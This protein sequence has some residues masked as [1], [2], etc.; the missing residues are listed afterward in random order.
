MKD[1]SSDKTQLFNE[2]QQ[3]NRELTLAY[4]ATIEGWSRALELRN[5]EIA[6]HSLRVTEMTLRLARKMG[7]SDEQLVHIR[8]GALLHDIGKL[9][10]PDAIL[11]KPDLLTEQER[12][13]MRQHPVL[14]YTL[15]SPIQ[16]L[17]PALDIVYCHHENWDGNGYSRGL[18]G[19][20]IPQAVCLF[21]VVN[22]WD[23]LIAD[24]PFRR[25]VSKNDAVAYIKDQGGKQF[26]PQAVE[27]FLTFIPE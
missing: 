25:G 19:E 26:D 1:E 12:Q 14:G 27:V 18:K 4:E 21:S 5:K 16:F 9:G 15:L 8:R 3:T 13:V 22:V 6:G 23:A 7:I 11:F 24:R 2:L 17:R 20:E 10:I